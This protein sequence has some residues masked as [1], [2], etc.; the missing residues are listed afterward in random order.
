[1]REMQYHRIVMLALAGIILSIVCSCQSTRSGAS[2]RSPGD[3]RK[4]EPE[5]FSLDEMQSVMKGMSITDVENVLGWEGFRLDG[6]SLCYPSGDRGYFM[7]VMCGRKLDDLVVTELR[8]YRIPKSGHYELIPI[9]SKR[10][11]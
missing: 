5:Y 2:E 3:R 6:G 1:M 8:Y 10:N 4:A 11:K 9:E 7:V